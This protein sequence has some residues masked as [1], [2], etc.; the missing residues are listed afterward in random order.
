MPTLKENGSIEI[1][2]ENCDK[3]LTNTYTY[4]TIIPCYADPYYGS[5]TDSSTCDEAGIITYTLDKEKVYE[6]IAADFGLEIE[7][8]A[9]YLDDLLVDI[10]V[11]G[12]PIGHL[13]K[14]GTM[15]L[16]C[17][18]T[19]DEEG[20]IYFPCDRENC[21]HY[22]ELEEGLNYLPISSITDRQDFKT[23]TTTSTCNQE[24]IVTVILKD[25]W[26]E[27]KLKQYFTDYKTYLA[28]DTITE[29]IQK[30]EMKDRLVD[31]DLLFTYDA[32]LHLGI[33]KCRYEGCELGGYEIT[34]P[35][36]DS[37][38]Y[39]VGYTVS[40]TCSRNGYESINLKKEYAEAVVAE[41]EQLIAVFGLEVA[42]SN[43][44]NSFSYH[45]KLPLDYTVHEGNYVYNE[46]YNHQAPYYSKTSHS[47]VNGYMGYSCSGC[48]GIKKVAITRSMGVYEYTNS[49]KTAYRIKYTYQ[50]HVLY[51]DPITHFYYQVDYGEGNVSSSYAVT[52]YEVGINENISFNI[53]SSYFR[54]NGKELNGYEVYVYGEKYT[55]LSNYYGR[56]VK[57][58]IS[59][60]SLTVYFNNSNQYSNEKFIGNVYVK[61]IY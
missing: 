53:S 42:A 48:G 54:L 13:Y 44:A 45:R 50:G 26:L 24:G 19:L 20:K 15:I 7:D 1:K 22:R 23:K 39:R 35:D 27:T 43:L 56:A 11:E 59:S 36:Y 47:F 51:S 52:Y 28:N 31:H 34:L 6:F 4:R 37:E 10:E 14:S 25:N 33:G 41:N 9:P 46:F 58:G 5:F 32:E 3:Y 21:D 8:V 57:T 30:I 55:N 2:C 38:A 61:I 16:G 18:P 12:E 60:P 49:A 17:M 40:S 29:Q